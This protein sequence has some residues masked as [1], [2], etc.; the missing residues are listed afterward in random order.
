MHEKKKKNS[1]SPKS[2][3]QANVKYFAPRIRAGPRASISRN[4][5]KAGLTGQ[6]IYYI[7]LL[8]VFIQI[9]LEI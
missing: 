1:S 9:W 4:L 5:T 7:Y 3:L 8:L 2:V 6:V